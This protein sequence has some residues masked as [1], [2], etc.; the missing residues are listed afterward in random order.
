MTTADFDSVR[1]QARD[2]LDRIAKGDPAGYKALFSRG[3]DVTLGNPF[4]GFGRGW[5][6]VIERVERA[7]S[8]YTDGENDQLRDDHRVS[9]TGV[10]LHRRDRTIRDEGWGPP[11]HDRRRSAGHV[12]LSP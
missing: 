6:A 2:A 9:D 3:D 10:G 11:R 8:Y 7:A 1:T 12:C 5:V 4:G